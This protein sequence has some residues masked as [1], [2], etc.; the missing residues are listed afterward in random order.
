LTLSNNINFNNKDKLIKMSKSTIINFLKN[1]SIFLGMFLFLIF[2]TNN[3]SFAKFDV[4]KSNVSLV[5]NYSEDIEVEE[6]IEEKQPAPVINNPSPKIASPVISSPTPKQAPKS[7]APAP[8][9]K[10]DDIIVEE[11]ESETD[12]LDYF[13]SLLE[14]EKRKN[15]IQTDK[16]IQESKTRGKNSRSEKN[17]NNQVAN[18]TEQENNTTTNPS[19]MI[20][21]LASNKVKLSL[22]VS[23]D[24]NGGYSDF[25][26]ADEINKNY[27]LSTISSF[28]KD[29]KEKHADS[30]FMIIDLG[31]ISNRLLNDALMSKNNKKEST[32]NPMAKA[33]NFIGYDILSLKEKDIKD[34]TNNSLLSLFLKD[35]NNKIVSSNLYDYNGVLIFKPIHVL[36]KGNLK[37]AYLSFIASNTKDS[38][39]EGIYYTKSILDSY[40][41]IVLSHLSKDKFDLTVFSVEVNSIEEVKILEKF[42]SNKK[43]NIDI[44]LITGNLSEPIN[45]KIGKTYF[46]SHDKANSLL[47]IEL[48]LEKTGDSSYMLSQKN[49]DITINKIILDNK[50]APDNSISVLS[51]DF[52]SF[53]TNYNSKKL[54][55]FGNQEFLPQSLINKAPEYL[56][57]PS[58][59]SSIIGD[60]LLEASK[61]KV[62]IVPLLTNYNLSF[63]DN[64]IREVDLKELIKSLNTDSLKVYQ[65]QTKD[66]KLFLEWAITFYSFNSERS[67]INIEKSG[68]VNGILYL[69]QGDIRYI[70]NLK[71]QAG[72]RITRITDKAGKVLEDNAIIT[73][74]TLDAGS[75]NAIENIL[76]KNKNIPI[77][78][79]FKATP[80]DIFLKYLLSIPNSSSNYPISTSWNITNLIETKK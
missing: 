73:I 55:T 21:N 2:Y 38:N 11:P 26:Y 76:F 48:I 10:Q 17:Q 41:S 54:F 44:V 14:Q 40:D 56:V 32:E 60:T 53:L 9:K 13:D 78:K 37:I 8:Q 33:F 77:I 20:S 67:V 51:K 5:A 66:L 68:S 69:V 36:T 6:D 28:I 46:I 62:V 23:T 75:Q 15:Q 50:Y 19:T 18:Q 74:A 58:V 35:F 22:I 49:T 16:T 1:T 27:T 47:N 12:E 59:I 42:L 71:N 70:I 65:F 30:E 52:D 64:T 7:P 39:K 29:Y 45:D 31:G 72:N 4:Y 80:N 25:I 61:A 34:Y 79:N 43:Y 63:Y 3:Q 24:I 57:K